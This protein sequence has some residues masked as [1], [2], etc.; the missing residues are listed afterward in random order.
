MTNT[1]AISVRWF[2]LTALAVATAACTDD[3]DPGSS[4]PHEGRRD[5]GALRAQEEET[6]S[7][8]G[9]ARGDDD[10]AGKGSARGGDGA[11]GGA[12]SGVKD[13]PDAADPTDADGGEQNTSA[14]SS[15]GAC[16]PYEAGPIDV[17]P[18]PNEPY[19]ASQPWGV[20][21]I[22]SPLI[23][24]RWRADESGLYA[25]QASSDWTDGLQLVVLAGGCDGAPV[26]YDPLDPN[27]GDLAPYQGANT[28]PAPSE[29][30]LHVAA[31]D[32]YTFEVHARIAR[33]TPRPV[34]LRV[35]VTL[36]C[37][38]GTA[39]ACVDAT[40]G[41][42]SCGVQYGVPASAPEVECA[43]RAAPGAIDERCPDTTFGP[44]SERVEGCCR[45]DGV[46]G[47]VDPILGCHM[48]AQRGW[49]Y[50]PEQL[51]F[52][53]DDRA[54]ADPPDFYQCVGEGEPCGQALDC[55]PHYNYG[56][57]SCID[58]VCVLPEG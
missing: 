15:H 57:A 8:E 56:N 39:G 2:L 23:S 32:E 46:C 17:T 43:E 36:I 44:D 20:T 38:E 16:L 52:Y 25:V 41:E 24:L 10:V 49:P 4:A 55:C 51:R 50:S 29:R 5:G 30:A 48:Y 21:S 28:P 47:H 22:D 7:G 14:A 19:T 40:N 9:S 37:A 58:G 12:A 54:A 27:Q 26:P 1:V 45:P 33:R 34:L 42:L 6:V 53:C 31:G 13:G 11:G 3:A 18:G 35:D